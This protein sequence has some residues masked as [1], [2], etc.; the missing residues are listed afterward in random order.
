MLDPIGNFLT[1]T[2]LMH[3]NYVQNGHVYFYHVVPLMLP[4]LH[5]FVAA[6]KT[7]YQLYYGLII[8]YLFYNIGYNTIILNC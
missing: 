5:I 2:H 1:H 6:P 3:Q 7:I 8:I 4:L